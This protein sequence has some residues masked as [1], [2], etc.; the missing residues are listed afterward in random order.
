MSIPSTQRLTVDRAPLFLPLDLVLY[1]LDRRGEGPIFA[2][3]DLVSS[4]AI[5]G[6][7][8]IRALVGD[9]HE[10]GRPELVY[11]P[12]ETQY[13]AIAGVSDTS[14]IR[15]VRSYSPSARPR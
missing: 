9:Q 11:K 7:E 13:P 2:S 6:H 15:T 14:R 12:E 3:N 10:T 4:E 5:K 8:R 1:S